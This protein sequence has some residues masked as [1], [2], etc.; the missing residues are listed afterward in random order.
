MKKI[1]AIF[2]LCLTVKGINAQMLKPTSGFI[3]SERY[4]STITLKKADY[5]VQGEVVFGK[6]AVVTID[7]GV[8]I[9]FMPGGKINVQGGLHVNGFA[10][11]MVQFSS[12]GGK[13]SGIGLIINGNAPS[14]D[15][16]IN[17]ASFKFLIQPLLFEKDWYRN[18]VDIN[19]S[20]FFNTYEF[21]DAISIKEV[22]FYLNKQPLPFNFKNNVFSDNYSNI[23]VYNATSYRV[24]Y[25]FEN[26]VFANNLY[27]DRRLKAESN[28]VYV[29]LDD[30]EGKYTMKIFDNA[31]SD[32]YILTQDSLKVA[33]AGTVGYLHSKADFVTT[34][35]FSNNQTEKVFNQKEPN[36]KLHAFP[37][38]ISVNGIIVPPTTPLNDLIDQKIK[39]NFNTPIAPQQKEYTVFFNFIDTTT[40]DIL[41]KQLDK[42]YVLTFGENRD[43]YFSFDAAVFIEPTGYISI[44]NL[45]NIDGVTVP[46]TN[47]GMLD[48]FEKCGNRNYK[49]DYVTLTP[50][51]MLKY[52]SKWVDTTQNLILELDSTRVGKWEGGIF[53]GISGYAGDLNHDWF[54]QE[55]GQYVVGLMARYHFNRNIAARVSLNYTKVSAVDYGLYWP[56]NLGFR[57]NVISVLALG[58]YNFSDKYRTNRDRGNYSLGRKL[59]PSF[60]L[61]IGL[62][63]FDPQNQYTDGKWYSVRQFGTEG[64]TAPGGKKYSTISLVTPAMASANYRVNDNIKIALEFTALK[65]FTD[66]LDDMSKVAYVNDKIIREANPGNAD[67][68]SYFA[69][70]GVDIGARGNPTNKDFIYH[71]GLSIFYRF[72]QK[73][74]NDNDR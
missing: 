21:N 29:T 34:N 36:N 28:P 64:Q 65:L 23:S 3:L 19:N 7:S 41:K 58:E 8:R 49:M 51:D 74:V 15:I 70:P 57:S 16:K 10:N 4:D 40:G 52:N 46:S 56:R 32:N 37:L 73:Q 26:N 59:Y 53:G 43:A 48:F 71:F 31:F 18:N 60:G 39:I 55:K 42:N 54:H 67:M 20:D 47:I 17:Y 33:G 62:I 61:G 68:A 1:I 25:T 22:E 11:N 45:K 69:N 35:N 9:F 30:I 63:K 5:I 6:D 50:I 72:N 13:E 27:F 38:N 24:R 66:H 2:I 44:E 12:G 14:K